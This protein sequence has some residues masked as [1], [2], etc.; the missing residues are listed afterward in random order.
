MPGPWLARCLAR[1]PKYLSILT[2]PATPR[3]SAGTTRTSRPH[4]RAPKPR[5]SPYALWARARAVAELI[6]A[7]A[8]GPLRTIK[9]ALNRGLAA[10]ARDAALAE[11]FAQ[12]ESLATA[13]AAEGIAAL[14]AKRPPHFTGR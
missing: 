4:P 11:A 9:R 3:R 5:S 7:N 10:A 2:F 13:D 8:P 6:A 12:S 14:L 1:A